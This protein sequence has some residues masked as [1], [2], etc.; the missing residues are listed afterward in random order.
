MSTNKNN[1]KQII[2][3]IKSVVY[4]KQEL[5]QKLYDFLE[6]LLE[7][8]EQY[9]TIENNNNQ[10]KINLNNNR[11]FA[12][13][14]YLGTSFPNLEDCFRKTKCKNF[15]LA[16]LVGKN[17]QIVWN[18][19]KNYKDEFLTE[20][21]K[22]IYNQ[23]GKI[24]ISTG[25]AG[26]GDLPKTIPIKDCYNALKYLIDKYHIYGIDFDIEGENIANE[27]DIHNRIELIKLLKKDYPN[28]FISFT[29]PIDPDG[30]RENGLK[31]I[32]TTLL[33]T[34]I[35]CINLMT[36]DYGSYYAPNGKT[37]MAKYAIKCIEKTIGQFSNKNLKIGCT[38]MIGVNDVKDEI[39]TLNNASELLNYCLSNKNVHW[40]SFW[41]LN[42]DNGNKVNY[43]YASPNYS[44]IEQSLFDFTKLFNQFN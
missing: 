19:G 15:T 13:Y 34:K 36:M 27:N 31:L 7:L 23:G 37:D 25:G 12:P 18:N 2:E 35:D 33:Y 24:I 22:Y 14:V 17:E 30:L 21:L 29:I 40:L 4:I 6:Y 43:E 1:I 20:Q 44:G 28:L 10:N 11:L 8:N 39:F 3:K 26:N 38:S 41:S 42:R 5:N 9:N 16:F 32:N